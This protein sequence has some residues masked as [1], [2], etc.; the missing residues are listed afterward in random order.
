MAL[1]GH[2]AEVHY[3]SL[4]AP[5]DPV[6]EMKAKY[7]EGKVTEDI[8]LKCGKKFACY[9][10]GVFAGLNGMFAG[11]LRRQRLLR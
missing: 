2:E 4:E 11:I 6:T 8:C 5:N 3:H 1:L 7:R 9:S 10:Q